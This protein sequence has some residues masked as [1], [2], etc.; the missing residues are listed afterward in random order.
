M[1][2]C[3]LPWK[4]NAFPGQACAASVPHHKKLSPYLRLNLFSFPLLP[5]LLP[6]LV[7]FS[8]FY[9]TIVIPPLMKV[10]QPPFCILSLKYYIFFTFLVFCVKSEKCVPTYLSAIHKSKFSSFF[11][12]SLPHIVY[13]LFVYPETYFLFTP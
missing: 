7:Y 12:F 10:V 4:R 2:W 9:D 5:L 6:L 1:P 3:S 13:L 11:Q 8:G